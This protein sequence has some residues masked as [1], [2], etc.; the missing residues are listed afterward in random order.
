LT[1]IG[2]KGRLSAGNPCQASRSRM[3]S[4]G[5]RDA[6]PDN[7]AFRELHA[8]D[9]TMRKQSISLPHFILVLLLVA[10]CAAQPQKTTVGIGEV[11]EWVARPQVDQGMAATGCVPDSGDFFSDRE[12]ADARAKQRLV[13]QL[14]DRV[15]AMDEAYEQRLATKDKAASG[16]IFAGVSEQPARRILTQADQNKIAYEKFNGQK[17]LCVMLSLGEKEMKGFFSRLVEGAD[18]DIGQR[19]ETILYHVFTKGG[20]GGERE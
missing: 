7:P 6:S 11:P 17:H 14:R 1:A 12:K 9:G 3:E 5:A 13:Q 16:P 10:G 18:A 4:P 15:K 2:F 20:T 19:D 8:R